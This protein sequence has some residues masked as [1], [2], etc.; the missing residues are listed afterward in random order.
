MDRRK[1]K[2]REAIIKAYLD[3]ITE[4]G[5]SQVTISELARRANID[6]KTFYLHYNSADDV[7]S[8]YVEQKFNMIVSV[9]E[10]NHYFDSPFDVEMLIDLLDRFDNVL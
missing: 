8:E 7:L 6:R 1:V 2:T 9:M 10:E 3:L 4:K 5:T